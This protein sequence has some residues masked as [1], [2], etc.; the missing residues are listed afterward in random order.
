[1][2]LLRSISCFTRVACTSCI[3]LKVIEMRRCVTQGTQCFARSAALP[4]STRQEP[5]GKQG[6]RLVLGP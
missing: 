6:V 2:L 5:A 1:M 4:C 3:F